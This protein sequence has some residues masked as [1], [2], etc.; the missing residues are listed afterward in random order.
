MQTEEDGDGVVKRDAPDERSSP[1]TDVLAPEAIL[2]RL[3]GLIV[4]I[5]PDGKIVAA[6]GALDGIVGYE[7]HDLVDRSVFELVAPEEHDLLTEIFLSRADET[8]IIDRPMPFPVVLISADGVRETIDA[9]PNVIED[10]QRRGWIVQLTPQRL[11]S[12]SVDLID[13]VVNGEPLETVA[14]VVAG[15][16]QAG[17][18]ETDFLQTLVVMDAGTASARVVAVNADAGLVDAVTAA[19]SHPDHPFQHGY[20]DTR[21]HT[22]RLDTLGADARAAAEAAG[23]EALHVGVADDGG[24]AVWCVL[25]FVVDE[26]VALMQLNADLPRRAMLKII[27]YALERRRAEEMLRTAAETDPLTGVGNRALFDS[28]LERSAGHM[29]VGVVYTD[30][31]GFKEVNDT[32][33]H[34]VGDEVL[35]VVARRMA[36]ISRPVDVL[37]RVGGDEFALLVPDAE[38][39]LLHEIAQ[40]LDAVIT[41]PMM[42]DGQIIEVG[43]SAGVAMSSTAESD[44]RE[45]VRTADL[46]M[47]A[48]KRSS[49]PRTGGPAWWPTGLSSPTDA[50][51]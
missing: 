20:D 33:G 6:H 26:R 25:W 27:T 41:Q 1:G 22:V 35:Q 44:P 40:R 47:L 30:L 46:S 21:I 29:R 15:R 11:H 23:F 42:I 14:N 13:V 49:R 51:D 4:Q 7:T 16:E 37:A 32:Y 28:A 39:A 24:S 3:R 50:I 17:R 12:A 48:N 18:Q 19:F 43:A 31:D 10:G 9:L 8:A 34:A 5:D 2:G 38:P 45:L 36:K